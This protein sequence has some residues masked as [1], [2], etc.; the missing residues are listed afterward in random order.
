LESS[1]VE[2]V[3]DLSYRLIDDLTIKGTSCSVT[4]GIEFH[5]GRS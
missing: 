3:D 5:G 1:A 4:L 2:R